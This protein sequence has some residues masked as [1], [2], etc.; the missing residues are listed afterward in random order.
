[1]RSWGG[2]LCCTSNSNR[3]LRRSNRHRSCRRTLHAISFDRHSPTLVFAPLV[4][5]CPPIG[6]KR[7]HIKRM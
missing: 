2:R 7:L 1:L 6:V 4:L 5:F 3:R